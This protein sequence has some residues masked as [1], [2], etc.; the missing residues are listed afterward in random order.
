M[1]RAA[2]IEADVTTCQSCSS[3]DLES[4]LWV[5]NLPPC[6]DLRPIGEPARAQDTWPTELFRC[7][8]CELVQL[9][10]VPPQTVT[11]PS[12][13][14]Y[15]SS[16]TRALRENFADLAAEVSALHPLA[17]EDLVVDIG[18]ND[19]NLLSNFVGKQRVLNVT[20]EDIGALG[21]ERGIP[22]L[23]QYWGKAAADLAVSGHGKA[24]L[25]TATNVF[26][27][28]PDPHEFIEAALSALTDDGVF[29]TESHY[30]G[31]LLKGVQYDAVYGE[32]ARYLSLRAIENMLK[33]HGLTI[34]FSRTIDSHGGSIRVYACRPDYAQAIAGRAHGHRQRML[35]AGEERIEPHDFATFR[36]RVVESKAQLWRLL[37]SI[38]EM[39]G[40]VVGIGAP[41]RASTLISYVGI[42]HNVMPWIAETQG[43]HKIGRYAPGTRIEVREEVGLYEERVT[44]A[45]LL[46]HHIAGELVSSLAKKGFGGSFVTPLPSPRVV[47]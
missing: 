17:P 36:R 3:P 35:T 1:G 46:S 5:G 15:T 29:L 24:K 42:D 22:H 2:K 41:S 43:S 38:Q 47:Q 23:Q 10:F 11:F 4:V 9:G 45:L 16:T 7:P 13:Y 6:N 44:H 33:P 12:S 18:G 14:P 8:K 37:A 40:R 31:A 26:A 30:L 21:I 34:A 27:H 25:I 20:P 32:H 28:V 39:G 19:G